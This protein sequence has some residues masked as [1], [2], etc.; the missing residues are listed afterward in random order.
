MQSLTQQV[1]QAG[2]ELAFVAGDCNQV[3]ESM[4]EPKNG[5]PC[6]GWKK[7]QHIAFERWRVPPVAACK[8]TSRKDFLFLSPAL[9]RY[10]HAVSNSSEH[11]PDHSVLSATLAFPK[12]DPLKAC[13]P[14][15]QPV[16]HTDKEER[17]A[18]HNVELEILDVETSSDAVY[19]QT[20]VAFG[21]SDQKKAGPP[22]PNPRPA[23]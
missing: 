16:Q 15:P 3:F 4:T 18:I 12:A 11:F 13:W 6:M 21:S 7:I 5:R 1:V 22:R 2:H 20:C 9:Q 19:T 17:S 23:G 10:V 8:R 14:K